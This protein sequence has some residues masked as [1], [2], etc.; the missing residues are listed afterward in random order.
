VACLDQDLDDVVERMHFVAIE[1]QPPQFFGQLA[2]DGCLAG[3]GGAHEHN[4]HGSRSRLW[5]RYVN[6]WRSFHQIQ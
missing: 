1:K 3:T 2:S 6:Y 4:D 5:E